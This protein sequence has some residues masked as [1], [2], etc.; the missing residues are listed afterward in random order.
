MNR[1]QFD[2]SMFLFILGFL[3][4]CMADNS[5]YYQKATAVE[6]TAFYVLVSVACTFRFCF[7]TTRGQN[8]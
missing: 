6:E 1:S 3:V 4:G 7:E 2:Q 8:A 5:H